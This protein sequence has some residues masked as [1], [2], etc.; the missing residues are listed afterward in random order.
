MFYNGLFT[1]EMLIPL[2]DGGILKCIVI[3]TVDN[4]HR[5]CR[6]TSEKKRSSKH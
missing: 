2:V 1:S 5:H 4:R 6:V 3:D